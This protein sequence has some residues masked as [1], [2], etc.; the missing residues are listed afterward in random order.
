MQ[1]EES[2]LPLHSDPPLAAAGGCAG[3]L[4]GENSSLARA[5]LAAGGAGFLDN[6]LR[7]HG[8]FRLQALP[9]P[10][11]QHLA[12]GVLEA[13]DVVQASMV[14][15]LAQRLHRCRDLPV[16]HEVAGLGI[17]FTLDH[18]L[19]TKGV[20]VH[21]PALMP[22]RKRGQPVCGL[23]AEGFDE[24][25]GHGGEEATRRSRR[26]GNEATKGGSHRRGY[27]YNNLV[28]LNAGQKKYYEMADADAVNDYLKTHH[29]NYESDCADGRPGFG[30]PIFGYRTLTFR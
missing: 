25:D 21:A 5:V 8:Q 19:D 26:A 9:Q 18:D 1:G 10:F 15:L 11:G 28:I 7:E 16:V 17:D 4:S 27:A 20:S 2:L 14:E 13:F 6:H 30:E 3:S 22:L 12:G 29:P 24:T 23:E